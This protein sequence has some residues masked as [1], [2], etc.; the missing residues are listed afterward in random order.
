MTRTTIFTLLGWSLSG[1]GLGLGLAQFGL[2]AAGTALILAGVGAFSATYRIPSMCIVCSAAIAATLPA[3]A[4][5]LPLW[6]CII[7]AFSFHILLCD[8]SVRFI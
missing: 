3:L 6:A 4:I 7:G 5:G 8:L 2:P 1:A